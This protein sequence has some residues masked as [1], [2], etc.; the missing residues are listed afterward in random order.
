MG[1]ASQDEAGLP[2]P[3]VASWEVLAPA[4]PEAPPAGS[5][6]HRGHTGHRG[7]RLG[8]C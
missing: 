1:I 8:C 3:P 7:L 4:D 2:G 5:R 6:A